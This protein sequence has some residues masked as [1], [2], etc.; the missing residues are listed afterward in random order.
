MSNTSWASRKTTP[1]SR[2]STIALSFLRWIVCDYRPKVPTEFWEFPAPDFGSDMNQWTTELLAAKDPP[3]VW[4]VSYGFQVRFC[5]LSARLLLRSARSLL[6]FC[7][8][9]CSYPL[10][11]GRH[12]RL[13]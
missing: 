7:S 4:S 3:L 8:L 1:Q 12:F 9:C 5:S 11:F 10:C 6:T 2:E 13:Q